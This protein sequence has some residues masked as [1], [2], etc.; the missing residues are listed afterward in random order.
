[1]FAE[2]QFLRRKFGQ[3]YTDWAKDVPPFIPRFK[4][5]KKPHLPFSWKKV[6]KKEKNGLAALFLIFSAF[7]IIGELIEGHSNY[8]YFIIGCCLLSLLA[9]GIL[10]YL[11]CRTNLLN[12]AGR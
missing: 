6:L 4:K 12:E 5:F 9:Y 10:K 2:E 1:M 3:V 8:N 11:K 7:N